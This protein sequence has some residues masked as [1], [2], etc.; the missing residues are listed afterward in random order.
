MSMNQYLPTHYELQQRLSSTAVDEEWKAFDTQQRRYVTVRFVHM[1]TLTPGE[2]IPRFQQEMQ[3]IAAL[4]HPHIVPVFD[5]QAASS[6]A[7]TIGDAYV[8]YEYTDSY[9]LADYLA[10]GVHN[11]ILPQPQDIVQLFA[12][13]ATALDYA[14]QQGVIHGSLRP[15]NILLDKRDTT[16]FSAGKARVTN[17]GLRFLYPSLSLPLQD[18]YYVAPEI[19]QG[20]MGS[21]RSDLYTLGVLLYEMCTGVPP[22]QGETASE[23]M[24]QHIQAIPTAPLLINP[25]LPPA[26]VTVIMR[27]LAKDPAKRFGTAGALVATLAKAFNVPM[28]ET[29]SLLGISGA[30]GTFEMSRLASTPLLPSLDAPIDPMNSPTYLTPMP[31]I[32]T[33][34][35]VGTDV[36]RS[37]ASTNLQTPTVFYQTGQAPQPTPTQMPAT[38]IAPIALSVPLAPKPPRKRRTMLIALASAM[39]LLVILLGSALWIFHLLPFGSPSSAGKPIIGY[40][41]F[42]SS[43]LL[44]LSS[45][46]GI[47]DRVQVELNN[48]P[49]APAGKRYYAWLLNDN[50][51]LVT[52]S[53]IL[54]GALPTSGGNITL[55]YPGDALHSD[56]LASYSRFLVTEENASPTPSNPSLDPSTKQYYAAFSQIPNP[57]D[58]ENHFSLLAHLRHL[59][60]LDP[61]L[62][63]AGLTGGLDIWL[64]RNTEKILEYA[65]SARDAQQTGGADLVYRQ[66]V[67]I[68]DYLDGTQYIQTEPL[69]PGT[70]LLIDPTIAKVALL[71]FDVQHQTPPGYLKHIGNHL[72]EIVQSPGITATQRALAIQI[73]ADIDNVQGWLTNVHADAEKLA[74]MPN[75]QLLQP[76]A[77]ALL[78]DMFTQTNFAF[79]GQI[80]PNTNQLKPGVVQIHYSIQRLATFEIAPCTSSNAAN[81]C[82]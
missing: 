52:I 43:G 20:T 71:E 3:L 11:G 67:R 44:N 28:P 18:A 13:L 24:M 37:Q 61:K 32:S 76:Q 26:V 50:D 78:N 46:E 41:F 49:A 57:N 6:V 31:R 12:A 14:H 4:H 82:A 1:T 48:I 66:V 22:F 69:R 25:H 2:F 10:S 15:K 58:T 77:A 75:A 72:R 8:V 47:A 54:L 64:F 45:S 55:T 53:P 23:V 74:A 38:S 5:F 27:A 70:G 36:A 42:A 79:A 56:L 35:T 21:N 19:A 51:S 62:K 9:S 80:D 29:I 33:N 59:L 63:A 34:S 30:G 7:T 65:G 40:A 16:T 39:L 73:N 60:A 17:F 81:P 68:L